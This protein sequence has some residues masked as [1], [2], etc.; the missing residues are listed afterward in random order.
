MVYQ[1]KQPLDKGQKGKVIDMALQK[2]IEMEI[3]LRAW[4]LNNLDNE[5]VSDGLYGFVRDI[6]KE[7]QLVDIPNLKLI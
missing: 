2:M 7:I 1:T 6:L 3:D 4:T 5:K